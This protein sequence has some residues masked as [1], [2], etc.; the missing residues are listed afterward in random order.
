[1]VGTRAY[2]LTGPDA[3]NGERLMKLLSGVKRQ[4]TLRKVKDKSKVN[5]M[6]NRKASLNEEINI[7]HNFE[8][9]DLEA[10]S[11]PTTKVTDNEQ[12]FIFLGKNI[13]GIWSAQMS[14][15]RFAEPCTRTTE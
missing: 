5:E 6:P 9:R 2:L 8:F 3:S 10:L 1:M 13:G 15:K 7:K 14:L 12:C 11:T 4:V